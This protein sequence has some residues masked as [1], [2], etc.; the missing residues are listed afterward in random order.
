MAQEHRREYPSPWAAVES[1]ALKISCVS[2]TLLGW[3]QRREVDTG[4]GPVVATAE[5][6]RVK[7]LERENKVL[8]R[9][10]EILMLTSAFLTQAKLDCR[11]RS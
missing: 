11:L 10:N 1:I 7:E 4:V 3:L 8:R 2:Q 5:A 9:A 6:H